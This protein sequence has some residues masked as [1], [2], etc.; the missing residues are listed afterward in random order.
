MCSH[1]RASLSV[2]DKMIVLALNTKLMSKYEIVDGPFTGR[3]F[4][5]DIEAFI[6]SLK[7]AQLTERQ[8]DLVMSYGEK[9]Y[10]VVTDDNAPKFF[11]GHG[12]RVS[13]NEVTRDFADQDSDRWQLRRIRG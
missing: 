12:N 10:G 6:A 13:Y 11:D 8:K 4:E 1:D 9:K 5:G 3:T 7:W 2:P